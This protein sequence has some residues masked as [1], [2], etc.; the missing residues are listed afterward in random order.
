MNDNQLLRYSRHLLLPEIDIDGQQALSEARVLVIGVGGLGCS[1]AQSLA[2]SGVGTLVLVD[3][4]VVELSNLQRQILHKEASVGMTKVASAIAAIK[5]LN[6]ECQCV[7][8]DRRLDEAELLAEAARADLVLDCS[9]NFSTRFLLNR[10]C[11]A[12]KTP[13]VSGAAIRWEG[14]VSVFPATDESPCYHC[15]Y[16]EGEEEGLTC[17]ESGVAAPLVGMVGCTQALEAVKLLVG[18]GTPLSGRLLVLDALSMQWRNFKLPKDPAC[19]V[20]QSNE[21]DM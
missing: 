11:F 10:V 13:L 15:L 1:A 16:K 2:V 5:E 3:D 9:D 21:Q 7:G 6:S 18:A 4:D 17:S 8:I 20:C 14:Q 19:P 12:V